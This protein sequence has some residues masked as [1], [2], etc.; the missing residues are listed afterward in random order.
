MTP[1]L[2]TPP[3]DSAASFAETVESWVADPSVLVPSLLLLLIGIPSVLL[4]GRWTRNWVTRNSSEQRGLVI[5]RLITYAGLLGLGVTVLVQLGFHLTP[6]LGAAGILGIALG[7]ASQTSVSNLISGFF[8]MGEQSFVVGDVIEVGDRTGTVL[9]IDMLSVKLRT[10]DNKLVR[11]PNET[12]V[13]SEV[14]TV[15]RFPIRRIDILLG[16][17]YH[18]NLDEVRELLFQ[19]ARST[20][21]V[22]M[23]PEPVFIFRAFGDSSLDLQLGVWATRESW[24][25]TKNAVHFRIKR[26]LD[27][28][29]IEIPFPQR[30]IHQRPRRHPS[31]GPRADENDSE[32]PAEGLGGDTPPL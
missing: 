9:S 21:G 29:G 16:V 14:V 7:F 2:Q 12:L 20:P 13:K 8:I 19:I 26:G 30:T 22:L 27:E 25:E 5:G 23:E 15:T 10:F 4:V 28:A 32:F 24:L 1:L 17:A 31:V 18:E 3:S 6:L 11:I